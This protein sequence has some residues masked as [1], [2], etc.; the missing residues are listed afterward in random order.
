M[1]P[2]IYYDLSNEDY[3]AAPGISVSGLKAILRSPAHFKSAEHQSTRAMEIGSAIHCAALEPERF[4]EMYHCADVIDRRA[5]LYKRL[6][7]QYGGEYVLTNNESAL[8]SGMSQ[9]LRNHI[10]WPYIGKDFQPEVSIFAVEPTYGLLVK[11]RFDAVSILRGCAIDL[12]K[13]QDARRDAFSRAI[14]NYQYHMQDAWYRKVFELA[15]G[16]ALDDFRFFAVEEKKPH[17]VMAYS[18]GEE[19]RMIGAALCEDALAIYA[20]CLESDSWPCYGDAPTED[21]D[22]PGWALNEYENEIVGEIEE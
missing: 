10:E 8:V 14:F 11:C 12:K 15:T 22:I 13:T 1:K 19:S 6:A 20:E 17:G 16:Y 21:I 9:A 18:I 2:G 7:D 5:A 3:H 4:A